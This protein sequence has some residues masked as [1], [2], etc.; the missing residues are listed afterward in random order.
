MSAELIKAVK[1]EIARLEA[2]LAQDER[3]QRL[4]ELRRVLDLYDNRQALQHSGSQDTERARADLPTT[5]QWKTRRKASKDRREAI[6]CAGIVIDNRAGPVPTREILEQLEDWKVVV[7]GK[8]PL[9]NL[10]AMLSNSG[11]FE[12]HGRAGWTRK[13]EGASRGEEESPTGGDTDGGDKSD[14][15]QHSSKETLLS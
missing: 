7:P 1:N 6:R 9:N 10:S 4:Q 5:E 2:E 8:Q 13:S 3:Y 15:E 11:E 12:S 14:A